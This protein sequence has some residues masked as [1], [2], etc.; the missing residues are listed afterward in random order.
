MSARK[1]ARRTCAPALVLAIALFALTAEAARN[2]RPSRAPVK[3]CAW[4]QRADAAIGLDAWVQRC[5]FGFRKID[6]VFQGNSLAIRYSDGGA[7]D[8][9]VDVIDVNKGE[10]PPAA[11]KRHFAARTDAALARR[12]VLARYRGVA[13]R[14]GV[15]RYTF[16]PKPAYRKELRAKANPNEVGDPPCGDWGETPDGIQYYEAAANRA[17]HKTLFVRVG[18][19]DPLFDEKTLR[20]IAPGRTSAAK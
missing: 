1:T 16:V 4:E 17:A 20:V 6:F 15:L 11:I 3:G 2:D 12:C 8:P 5:D 14:P 7:P 19:D 10:T 18:Q 13:P 9:V